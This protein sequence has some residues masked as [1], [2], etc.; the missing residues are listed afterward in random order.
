[1]RLE[2]VQESLR[3]P[4]NAHARRFLC[5]ITAHFVLITESL[6]RQM[7]NQN[8]RY[9]GSKKETC[10]VVFMLLRRFPVRRG[11]KFS[12]RGM[13]TDRLVEGRNLWA[14]KY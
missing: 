13:V 5:K 9:R 1:M 3:E 12:N 7:L 8:K 6:V 14:C 2:M 4:E 11:V 10:L